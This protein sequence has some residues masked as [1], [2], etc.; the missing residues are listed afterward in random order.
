MAED[1]PYTSLWT[2]CGWYSKDLC[3]PNVIDHEWDND[4]RSMDDDDGSE[5]M[6]GLLEIDI[7]MSSS[8]FMIITYYI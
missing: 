5:G 8:L 6:V 4:S 3:E 1:K 7:V 2:K